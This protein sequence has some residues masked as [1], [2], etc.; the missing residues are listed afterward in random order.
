MVASCCS[1]CL[2]HLPPLYHHVWLLLSLNAGSRTINL[3]FASVSR[4]CLST[5]L[6]R[7]WFP[8]AASFCHTLFLSEGVSA[9]WW[10]SRIA[11]VRSCNSLFSFC[12]VGGCCSSSSCSD[13][14][15]SW[16]VCYYDS[17]KPFLRRAVSSWCCLKLSWSQ[18]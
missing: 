18:V 1:V 14:Q 10:S 8:G 5:I 6:L 13:R 11:W 9:S 15:S 2:P 17:K 16:K 7:G 4:H 12:S 3:P